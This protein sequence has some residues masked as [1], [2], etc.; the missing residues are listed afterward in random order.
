M[1]IAITGATGQLGQIVVTK[2]KERTNAD[3][4]V[5]LV[6]TPEKAK[7]LG[8]EVRNFDYT[9]IEDQEQALKGIDTLLL[10]SSS[11]VG[12]R[13]TQHKN[14]IDSAKKAGVKRIAYTSILCADAS[15]MALAP[16]HLIT[17]NA[18][19]ES[20]IDY[21]ILR[22]GWY[23]E[24]YA[25]NIPGALQAGAV[26]G[27]AGDGKISSAT[28]EDFA[29]AA[30]A[31]LTTEG[32][33]NK[34]YELAGDEA[35]TLDDFASEI[36]KQTGKNIPYNNLSETEYTSA[37]V[38]VGV[39]EY[40]AKVLADSDAKAAEGALYSDDKTLSKLIGHSTTPLKEI[41]KRFL[42]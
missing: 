36:S 32:H 3:N 29:E 23:T 33:N 27:C 22:N 30:V 25:A 37:L 28:R 21:T 38:E 6:R 39:P 1:K 24:N 19:K 31:V 20:G 13:A 42:K 40:F 15:K 14:V 10:I 8:I 35:Y 4:L 41:V 34:I 17:E 5:A 7:N 2:L 26:I 11:E 18:L 16:E 9:K 12:Q